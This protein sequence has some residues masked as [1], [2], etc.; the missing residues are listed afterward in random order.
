VDFKLDPPQQALRSRVIAFADA[1]LDSAAAATLDRHPRYPDELH[2]ALAKAG[3]LGH[4]LPQEFGGGGGNVMDAVLINQALGGHG[5]AAVNILFVNFI[6]A[7]LVNLIGSKAQKQDIIPA[8]ARGD[9]RLAFALTEPD[10]GS[11]AG[12]IQCRADRD[13][14]AYTLRGVKLYTTGAQQADF[15]LTVALTDPAA[16]AKRGASLFLVPGKAEGLT[17]A[18][19][20]KIAGNAVSSCR[21][22]YEGVQ[23]GADALLG[24]QN[25]A[26]TPLMAGAG[27]ERVLVAA[28]CLGRAE[29]V[30]HE[31]IAFVRD[32]Q[33]FG[34]PIGSFQAIQ[35]QLADMATDTEA[36]RWLV[37]HAAS[38][39]D[40]GE[41]P[42]KEVSM[43]KLYCA[44]HLNEIV[45]RGMR[46]L[47]GRAYLRDQSMERHLRESLLGLYAGGTAEMQR[48]LIA[49]QLGLPHASR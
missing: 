49:R 33:Q 2:A 6:G 5:D 9:L 21:V 11:D 22:T 16:R 38:L 13:G 36:M 44:E 19:L 35:H 17:V 23:V 27:L 26:W 4:C 31:A 25:G 30:L 7:A 8:V 46:L 39:I 18:P 1:H 40:R 37:Y 45:N 41:L 32:R 15:I 12:S 14:D 20:D 28:S 48:N 34:Q 42:V 47:G 10:A 29:R 3:L 43:A 24:P